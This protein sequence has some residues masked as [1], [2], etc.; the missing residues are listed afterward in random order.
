MTGCLDNTVYTALLL[1]FM[2]GITGMSPQRWM[3]SHLLRSYP[4][5]RI[6]SSEVSF[7]LLLTDI[8]SSFLHCWDRSLMPLTKSLLALT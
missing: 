3:S 5:R 2:W 4:E 6:Y 7:E 1:L 8:I